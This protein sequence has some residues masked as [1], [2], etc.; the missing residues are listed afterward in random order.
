MRFTHGLLA[1]LALLISISHARAAVYEFTTQ[2]GIVYAEHDGA[3]LVGDLYHPKGLAKAPVLVAIH[4]G[5]F[6][7]GSKAFY[8]YWGAFLARN[9]YA[10]FAI[11][12]RLGK[13][14]A[15][16]AAIYDSKAA[17]QFLRAKAA[18]FDLNPDRIALIGDSS[19]AYLAAM[20]ALAADQ[21]ISAYRD[22]PF[23]ATSADVKAVIGFY[24][25]Y[26]LQAQWSR[27]LVSYPGAGYV[28]KFLGTSPMQNRRLYFE[29]SPISYAT[30]DR[31]K[32]RFLLIHGTN[33]DVIDP[34]SQ[35]GAFLA[36]LTQAGFFVRRIVIPGAGHFWASDPFEGEPRSY[37]ATAVPRLMRFLDKSL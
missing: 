37:S 9:G 32:A 20:V 7:G 15:Y 29:A 28:E 1:A 36:A 18:E 27:E 14:G 2:T 19:G 5:G 23:A 8:V 16:P 6:Q 10:V 11:D 30:V 34:E 4:G 35:S 26:D 24:G 3:K 21:F 33:D 12:Y 17:V 13:P 31:N 22:D 25:A